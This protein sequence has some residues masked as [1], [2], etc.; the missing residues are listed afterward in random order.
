VMPSLEPFP[1]LPGISGI[2]Y[3]EL[4]RTKPCL[5]V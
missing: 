4:D 1:Q 3:S 5:I 2:I